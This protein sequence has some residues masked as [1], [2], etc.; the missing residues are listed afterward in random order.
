M[1][2]TN[3]PQ[4]IKRRGILFYLMVWLVA[5]AAGLFLLLVILVLLDDEK[6][7]TSPATTATTAT[8][9]ITAT[10]ATET[11][12]PLPPSYDEALSV[13]YPAGLYTPLSPFM[14][15]G[16]DIK[17]KAYWDNGKL[18]RDVPLIDGTIDQNTPTSNRFSKVVTTVYDIAAF[19]QDGKRKLMVIMGSV[20]VNDRSVQPTLGAA[21][22]FWNGKT[23]TRDPWQLESRSDDLSAIGSNGEGINPGKLVKLGANRYGYILDFGWVGQGKI[24]G[25]SRVIG[26]NLEGVM[27]MFSDLRMSGSNE[28]AGDETAKY[29]FESSLEILSNQKNYNATNDVDPARDDYY[30]IRI[31]RQGT[32]ADTHGAIVKINHHVIYQM[33][34]EGYV[35]TTE[36][37][38]ADPLIGLCAPD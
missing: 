36:F 29:A 15:F 13:I 34:D 27:T 32:C 2:D 9:A 11:N 38:S 26:Q 1:N 14:D 21:I 10:A 37:N 8:Q 24:V 20:P 17:G 23:G 28:G 6:T 4:P 19:A 18:Y 31:R 30:P 5:P 25:M 7:G 33:Y 22:L 12:T 16:D 3:N 35:P